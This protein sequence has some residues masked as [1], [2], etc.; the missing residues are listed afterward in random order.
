MLEQFL[1]FDRDL[2]IYLNNLGSDNWDLLWLIITDKLTFLPFFLIII[3]FIYK[4]FTIKELLFIL[5]TIALLILFTDQFTNLI[6][7]S[8]QRLRP[9]RDDSINFFL[10]SIDV[11]CG[12]FGFFSAHAANSMAVSV[13]LYKL[14]K[15]FKI[16]NYFLICWV[17][18]FSYSRIYLGVHFPVDILFGLIFGFFF[19]S[20][21]YKLFNKFSVAS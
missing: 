14:F 21:A 20:I 17:I 11:R 1:Q 6:K 7:D 12:K 18:V 3:Y 19:G 8:F 9:C 13:F 2:L 5:L 16:L 10:R 4:K 15:N